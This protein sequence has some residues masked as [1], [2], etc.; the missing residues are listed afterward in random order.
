ME[1][2]R[3]IT[4]KYLNRLTALKMCC[5]SY[6]AGNKETGCSLFTIDLLQGQ[7]VN[8]YYKSSNC[9]RKQTATTTTK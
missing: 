1:L 6:T 2:M 3:L 4:I 7:K 5:F 9:R 8:T